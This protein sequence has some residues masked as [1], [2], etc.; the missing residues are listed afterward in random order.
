MTTVETVHVRKTELK[1]QMLDWNVEAKEEQE[2]GRQFCEFYNDITK[3]ALYRSTKGHKGIACEV[4]QL[5][6]VLKPLY[7]NIS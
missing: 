1:I 6:C 7:Y 5:R 2:K 4:L 3:C